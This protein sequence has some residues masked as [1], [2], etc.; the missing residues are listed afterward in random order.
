M[1]ALEPRA[2]QDRRGWERPPRPAVRYGRQPPAPPPPSQGARAS[3][4]HR[5][6]NDGGQRSGQ[7]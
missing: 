6:A 7:R 1:A 2:A 3:C 4:L 5:R